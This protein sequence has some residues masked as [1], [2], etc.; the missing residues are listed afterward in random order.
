MAHVL[1]EES[2]DL[3]RISRMFPPT[4]L[5][6]GAEFTQFE[7][8]KLLY[9]PDNNLYYLIVSTCN[10]LF[11][12]QSDDEVDKKV[13]LYRSTALDGPWEPWGKSGS[14]ILG[15]ENLF[16]MTVL[17]AD[18]AKKRLLCIAPYT[19]AASDG[20]RLTFSSAFYINLDPVEVLFS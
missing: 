5:P 3:F 10:R 7:L 8:P 2:D 19:D 4:T 9:D 12:G 18:F 17:K 1:L 14:V 6:D 15:P 16:G 11:E 20:L 13:R